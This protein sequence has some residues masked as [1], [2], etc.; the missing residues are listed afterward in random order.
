MSRTAHSLA[1]EAEPGRKGLW[2]GILAYRW[3]SFAWMTIL[4]YLSRADFIHGELAWT[5]LGL[6]AAWNVWLTLTGG[7]ERPLVRWIDLANSFGLLVVSGLV[8]T[9]RGVELG[10]APFFATAYPASSALTVGAGGGVGAGLVGGAVL[11]VGLALSRQVNGSPI[12]G[13]S[14]DEWADLVNGMVYFLSAGGAAGLVSRILGRSGEELRQ[15]NEQAL[16]QRERAARLA[17][18]ESFG[19]R[20]HDSV[21]QTLA[22]V[23]KRARELGSREDVA[24]RE[25]LDL[26][27]MAEQQERALRALLQ[28][29][30]EDAPR[31]QVS[32]RTILEASA[33]G[34]SG[35]P[36]TVNP[37]G[38]IW[39]P[40][41]QVEELSAAV[42]QALENA[43]AHA[44]ASRVVVYAERDD[45]GIVVSIRDDGIGFEYDEEALRREGKLGILKSMKG[46][47]E[48]LG[49]RMI[50]H[51]AAGQ[52]TEIEFRVPAPEDLST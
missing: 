20:I 49:G 47:I 17:E 29:V 28:A 43:A 4:A 10:K 26:A 45:A 14:G 50:V 15:A 38:T 41:D 8:V 1:R 21:L 31:G 3:V 22:L 46:R 37:V 48:E 42:R 5:V 32:L 30:P 52:G 40:A 13:L 2:L 9:E 24:G 19:R 23:N 27:E 34:V 36:V 11:S 44:R 25:V 33:F 39:L 12:V 7:W 16:V 18:R 35:A 51:S 6:T